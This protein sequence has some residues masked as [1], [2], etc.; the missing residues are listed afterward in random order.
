MKD[1][2]KDAP[3]EHDFPAAME[4][5]TLLFESQ[6]AASLVKKLKKA[7][8]IRRKA[9]DL[10]RASGLNLLPRENSHVSADLKKIKKRKLLSPVLLVRGNGAAGAP[11]IVAD[12][13]HRVC[14]SWFSDENLP[15]ACRL[16]SSKA[17]D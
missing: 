6:A 2:W 15:I 3:E 14:A 17:G 10:M 11:L 16:V 13:F 7:P 5:L 4:Y 8:T 9:K 12:G 1:I